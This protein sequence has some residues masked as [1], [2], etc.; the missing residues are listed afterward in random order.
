MDGAG[1]CGA[2]HTPRNRLGAEKS[3]LAYLA[4]GEAEGWDAPPLVGNHVPVQWTENALFQYLRT[5]FSTEHGVAAGPMG[6][7]VAGLAA[8]PESD[9]RAIAHYITSLSPKVDDATAARAVQRQSDGANLISLMGME[10]GRRAFETA[11]AVCHTSSGGVGHLGVRPL[12]GLNTSVA[13]AKPDNLLHVLLNG[14]DSPA[15]PDLGYM[16]GFRG[17]YDDRQLAE[18]VA[19]IRARYAPDQPAWKNLEEASGRIRHAAH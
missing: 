6:P 15:T 10:R 4:G 19:Y 1:H 18:L 5:G 3:G 16:P 17:V 2:C 8:L 11:C 12:M 7:V 9:V 14:I 13:H